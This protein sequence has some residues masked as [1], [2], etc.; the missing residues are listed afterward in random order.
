MNS[1]GVIGRGVGALYAQRGAES[2][3][4]LESRKIWRQIS[5]S[6]RACYA[7]LV[8]CRVYVDMDVDVGV[9]VLSVC[10]LVLRM[11]IRRTCGEG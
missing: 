8:L 7:A 5:G 2:E 10:M 9:G 4:A 1:T 6:E 3:S 11:G